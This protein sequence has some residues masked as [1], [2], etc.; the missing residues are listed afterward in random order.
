MLKDEDEK[1]KKNCSAETYSTPETVFFHTGYS[2][3]GLFLTV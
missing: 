1:K 3:K 2:S